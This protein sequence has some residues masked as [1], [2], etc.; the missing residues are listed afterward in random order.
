VTCL[1]STH[2]ELVLDSAT[3]VIHLKQGELLAEAA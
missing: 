3:R 1:I 2:D